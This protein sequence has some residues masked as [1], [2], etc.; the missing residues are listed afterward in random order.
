MEKSCIA[1]LNANQQKKIS[2]V[3]YDI[4]PIDLF[5]ISDR[6]RNFLFQFPSINLKLN[7]KA[8][9]EGKLNY[10]ICTD[11]RLL[12]NVNY[13]ALG[14]GDDHGRVYAFRI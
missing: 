7:Y 1:C 10:S 14:S 5:T 2:Q 8:D 11:N 13:G 9:K 12:H 6:I 3:I 4:I